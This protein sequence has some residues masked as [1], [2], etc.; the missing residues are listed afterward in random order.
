MRG[1]IFTIDAILALSAIAAALLVVNAFSNTLSS[2]TLAMHI[3]SRDYADLK[4]KGITIPE[5]LL[6]IP[7]T[8]DRREINGG[9]LV[10]SAVKS[11]YVPC[12]CVEFPCD[13]T[14]DSACLDEPGE[15]KS[16]QIWSVK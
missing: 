5:D 8:E 10:S 7:V 14:G 1:L 16:I 15:V 6:T 4:L 13:L 2:D 3:T 11:Y 9:T 12:V